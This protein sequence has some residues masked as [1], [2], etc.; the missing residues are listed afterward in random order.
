MFTDNE[1]ALLLELVEEAK[2]SLRV[3]V[4]PQNQIQRHYT[5]QALTLKL[6]E[7]LRPMN[8]NEVVGEIRNTCAALEARVQVQVEVSVGDMKVGELNE[9]T[10]RMESS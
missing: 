3:R 10:L 8:I 6:S 1:K 7:N 2:E 5:L 9:R 4:L